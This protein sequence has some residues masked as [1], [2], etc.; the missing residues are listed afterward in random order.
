MVVRMDQIGDFL[1]SRGFLAAMITRY[2]DTVLVVNMSVKS[3]AVICFPSTD[4]V[5]VDIKKFR[6]N[7]VYRIRMLMHLRRLGVACVV[8][9]VYSRHHFIVDTDAMVRASGAPRKIGFQGERL[10]G[11]RRWIGWVTAK[12]YTDLIETKAIHDTDKYLDLSRLLGIECLPLYRVQVPDT[13]F[14]FSNPYVVIFP[15]AN[16]WQRQ[17]PVSEWI[18]TLREIQNLQLTLVICGDKP[19]PVIDAIRREG[20]VNLVDMVSKTSVIELLSLLKGAQWCV[21]VDGGGIHLAATVGIRT[22]AI[23]GGGHWGRFLPYPPDA[24][25]AP[26]ALGYPMSCFGCRW[27]CIYPNETHVPCISNISHVDVIT[28]LNNWRN[29][30]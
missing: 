3:V 14:D 27:K 19:S 28:V 20:L 4:V 6:L 25:F 2:P 26:V 30:S 11:I 9:P 23:V 7:G 17:W 22:L 13:E 29:E 12:C 24:Q 21:G 18:L 5:A 10:Y 1:L 16:T 8:H 15:A